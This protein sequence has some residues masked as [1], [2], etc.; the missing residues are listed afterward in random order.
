MKTKKKSGK[1][2]RKSGKSQGKI[3]EFDVIKSRKPGEGGWNLI[4]SK[5]GWREVSLLSIE[6]VE[7]PVE[8][9]RSCIFYPLVVSRFQLCQNFRIEYHGPRLGTL[10]NTFTELDG[11]LHITLRDR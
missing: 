2:L 6:G 8:S 9:L 5:E 3:K 11:P 4:A 10:N 7:P 1:N